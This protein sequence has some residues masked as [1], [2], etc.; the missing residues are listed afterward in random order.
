[1]AMLAFHGFAKMDSRATGRT[2]DLLRPHEIVYFCRVLKIE[3]GSCVDL[4]VFLSTMCLRV[5]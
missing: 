1:M 3:V 5:S 2:V 4:G